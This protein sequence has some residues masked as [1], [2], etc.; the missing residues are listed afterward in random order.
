MNDDILQTSAS[1]ADASQLRQSRVD[2]ALQDGDSNL[3]AQLSPARPRGPMDGQRSP[4][5]EQNLSHQVGLVSLAAGVDPKYIGS[6]SGYFF[7]QMLRSTSTNHGSGL[8]GRERRSQDPRQRLERDI[9]V[10]AFKDIPIGLPATESLTKQLSETYFDTIHLQHPFLHKPSHERLIH[11]IFESDIQDE[12]AKFQVTMVL[13]ISALVLSRRSHV[14]LPSAGWCAAAVDKFS[15]LHVENS[16]RGLQ[17]LLLLTIYAMHSPSSQF[18]AW[19][20]NYQC[21]AMVIDLGLQREPS[22]IASLSFL[23]KEMRTR[24][25]WVVYSLDRKLSTMMGRPIGLR[26]EACDLRA[27]ILFSYCAPSVTDLCVKLPATVNDDCLE[28]GHTIPNVLERAGHMVYAVQFFKLARINSEMKYV[29]HSVNRETPSYAYPA[30]RD[31]LQWQESVRTQLAEWYAAIPHISSA[32]SDYGDLLCKT[33]YHTMNMLLFLPSPG[34]PQPRPESLRN[35]YRSSISAIKLFRDMYARDMLVYNWSTCHA[36]IL[37]AFCLIYCV[38][39]VA[40]LREETSAETLLTSIRA[41]SDI[42]SATGEYWAGARKSRDL[43]NELASRTLLRDL[44]QTAT[45]HDVSLAAQG[46]LSAASGDTCN[47]QLNNE[48][49]ASVPA[50]QVPHLGEGDIANENSSQG[51]VWEN[52]DLSFLFDGFP[53][54]TNSDSHEF[55]IGSLFVDAINPSGNGGSD[56]RFTF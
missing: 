1:A 42:L 7:T 16:L 38:T 28:Q 8:A 44:N 48:D 19:S 33:Q 54:G 25:F 21:I 26:D 29:L 47:V 50:Y 9:A 5:P 52:Q 53:Y 13:S 45:R 20:I 41:A 46:V 30:V 18:N 40:Q 24:V 23:Q 43:L 51:L 4:S 34:L 3:D 17:C 22:R 39:T 37:H 2:T 27:S 56:M 36:V 32:Q 12:I 11:E 15:S 10:Q 6:S 14:E 35:C 31:M 49:S 55:D